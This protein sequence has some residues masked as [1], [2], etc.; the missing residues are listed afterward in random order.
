MVDSTIR[1]GFWREALKLLYEVS[2][3]NDKDNQGLNGSLRFHMLG[4]VLVGS[5][6]FNS[7][8]YKRT[9]SII[10][11]SHFNHYMLQ[12]IL[13]GRMQGNF[14]GASIRAGP[15]DILIHDLSQ[16]VSS[17][18]EAGSR[19]T[20]VMPR[21]ELEKH[22]GLCNLHGVVLKAKAAITRLLAKYLKEVNCTINELTIAEAEAAKEAILLLLAS[23]IHGNNEGFPENLPVSQPMRSRILAYIE[24]NIA[25]PLM[26]PHSLMQ[27]FRVSRSHLYRTLEA[28]GGVAK[29]IRDRRL[30]HANRILTSRKDKPVSFKEIAYHCGFRDGTQF[31]RAFRSRFGFSPKKIREADTLPPQLESSVLSLHSHLTCQ[32]T[33]L[34][35]SQ[36]IRRETIH[37]LKR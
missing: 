36:P 31:V 21:H 3:L 17:E 4:T 30:D 32:A 2:P 33:K 7:Q 28:D 18:V 10:A 9:K 24:D 29:A 22:V 5:V 14:N 16:V 6:T 12:L 15:G 1:D 23:G 35:I 25:N 26:G 34:D 27:H 11:R 37:R 13:A 20:V 19:I 8:T